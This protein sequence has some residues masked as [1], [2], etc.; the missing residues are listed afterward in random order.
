M[1]DNGAEK[2]A[3]LS[4]H[5]ILVGC[6]SNMKYLVELLFL[7]VAIH[8]TTG[9]NCG[10][11]FEI[12]HSRK[13]YRS[14]ESGNT[15][16]FVCIEGYESSS[17]SSVTKTCD[18]SG[19]WSADTMTCDPVDCSAPAQAPENTLV[20][21]PLTTFMELAT[22]TCNPGY[23]FA[24]ADTAPRTRTCLSDKTWSTESIPPCERISCP[25]ATA[26]AN[27]YI[28]VDGGSQY[29]DTVTLKCSTGYEFD[30][31]TGEV[32][33]VDRT[34]QDDKTWSTEPFVCQRVTC[35]T[36]IVPENAEFTSSEGNEFE[37]KVVVACLTG[38]EYNAG[39]TVE[40]ECQA[41][42]TW[43]EPAIDCQR[44][45]CGALIVPD[46]AQVSNG[47]TNFESE[48]VFTCEEG[49]EDPVLFITTITRLCQAN[50]SWSGQE[51]VCERVKC[52]AVNAPE[53]T[54]VDVIGE[55]L[56][57]GEVVI[58]CI[59]GH[60]DNTGSAPL[61]S[62]TRTCQSDK[63]L[64]PGAI[65][66]QIVSCGELPVP[67]HAQQ[68]SSTGTTFG[69]EKVHTCN[70]GYEDT[71]MSSTTTRACEANKGWSGQTLDC[72][73][74][75]CG[76]LPVPD[77]AQQTSST[78]T[79]FGSE[80]V[81]TCNE[82][83][84]D[85]GMSPTTTRVCE[86]NKGWSGQALDCQRVKCPA[87]IAPEN[88]EVDVIGEVLYE[89][90]VVITCIAGHEDNTGSAPLTSITR[91]C[92]SNKTLTPGAIDCQRVK[93][94][95]VIAPENT[96]VDV[97]GEVLYE[98]EVVITC[99]AGH[100]DN[101]GSAPLT[102]ITQTCQ[103]NK[104]LTP[105]AID[106]Q[107][108]KCPAVIAPENTEVDVIGEVLYEGE[109]VITCIAG[110]EDNTGSAPLTSITRTCQS[111]K[112]LTPGAI[113][114]QIVDC[115]DPPEHTGASTP[116]F[117]TTTFES[118]ATYT[119]ESTDRSYTLTCQAN[120]DW[121]GEYTPCIDVNCGEAGDV[122]NANLAQGYGTNYQSKAHYTCIDGYES[123]GATL[124]KTCT[125]T[126]VWSNEDIV[127]SPVT[128]ESDPPSVAHATKDRVHDKTFNTKVNYHCAIGYEAVQNG[129]DMT[130]SSTCGADKNWAA[131]TPLSSC[132]I[133]V[134][135][136]ASKTL[137]SAALV[138]VAKREYGSEITYNCTNKAEQF[139]L[140]CNDRKK[141]DGRNTC[142]DAEAKRSTEDNTGTTTGAVF[143]GVATMGAS[144]ALAY[145]AR[146]R[147]SSSGPLIH[148]C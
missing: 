44:V 142:N 29:G 112:T 16:S 81:H 71:G 108:V 54:E 60:E 3:S 138:S 63:T 93:C 130:I 107:R 56:Y 133:K 76:E 75:S 77:N 120:K 143:G 68:T 50:K 105:G 132:T 78:G 35:P 53:N 47:G 136:N 20:N 9:T 109:V 98:G 62:I 103:S 43:I 7:V 31:G 11:A 82:G 18:S 4:E 99:I 127:C 121:D 66:C 92:Q 115:G 45:S 41:D 8:Q 86:A 123:T 14:L 145:L 59:A 80:K 2:G 39:S 6:S 27:A 116:S 135:D 46:N 22:Y 30:P 148:P 17:V 114:C 119:C 74:V 73:I 58:T 146:S 13:T 124:Q 94:P 26:P 25:A 131:A 19:S 49:H 101:T 125:D 144:G 111:D 5:T 23:E 52:P 36:P 38:Y 139:V 106:C 90:E 102:S 88:T 110:H 65:D 84:E 128:C 89:G 24:D 12:S 15:V 48:Q 104:T 69:S 51:L 140:K 32:E 55:V 118:E 95:A 79:T 83:Y 147:L 96:E 70:Q 28:H 40:Y 134:C 33:S 126:G 72:Q 122:A 67:D 85:A 141:W 21:A 64:T 91:T 10:C 57:E 42:R 34:C 129:T 1:F 97:I 117:S 87:V 37:D 113:D 137:A 61:T 100:E